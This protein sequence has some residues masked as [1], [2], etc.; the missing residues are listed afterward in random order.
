MNWIGYAKA[1]TEQQAQIRSVIIRIRNLRA[2]GAKD[3]R[4]ALVAEG[5]PAAAI[6]KA[7]EAE[8]G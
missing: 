1:G 4:A 2:G 8:N 6:I 5:W 7:M 3:I